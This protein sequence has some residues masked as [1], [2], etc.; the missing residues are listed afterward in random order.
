MAYVYQHIRLDTNEVFYVGIGSDKNYKRANWSY[1]RSKFWKSVAKNGFKVIITHDKIDF[2][3]CKKVEVSLIKFYGRRDI[4]TGILVN[5]TDGGD[6]VLRMKV[7][8]EQRIANSE[9]KKGTKVSEETKEKLRIAMTGRVYSEDAIKKMSTA[10]IGNK[11]G[12]GHKKTD[13]VKRIISEKNK[14]RIVSEIN[15]VKISLFHTGKHWNSKGVLCVFK[16]E[17]LYG[18][19]PS[20]NNAAKKIRSHQGNIIRVLNGERKQANG[21]T[22]KLEPSCHI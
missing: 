6:G 8:E 3:S 10:A 18:I 21:F 17:N 16:N 19:Y 11:K 4:G 13:E 2:E 7:T 14:G 12:L 22:F 15:K 9:R 20:I 5:M 1:G